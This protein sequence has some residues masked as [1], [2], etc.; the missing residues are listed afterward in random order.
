MPEVLP[1]FGDGDH[2]SHAISATVTG[3]QVVVMTA[4][5]TVAPSA[6]ATHGCAGIAMYDVVFN[7][8]GPAN[9]VQV[10]SEGAFYLTASVTLTA[11]T[12][13]VP[14]ANGAVAPA[15]APDRGIGYV[16]QGAAASGQALVQLTL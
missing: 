1:R 2:I 8:G 12:Y 16:I 11:G 10:T 4:D 7:A 14:A 15:T 13:V 9:N 5:R 3:G 6:D